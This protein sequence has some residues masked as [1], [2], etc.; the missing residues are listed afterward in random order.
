[1]A[2]E[3]AGRELPQLTG[4][5]WDGRAK[6]GVTSSGALLLMPYGVALFA[7]ATIHDIKWRTALNN[8]PVSFR[9]E[10]VP[11][12]ALQRWYVGQEAIAALCGAPQPGQDV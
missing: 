3:G 11:A 10:F 8:A 4:Q 9:H 5:S 7:V 12:F 1:M 6:A 2:C